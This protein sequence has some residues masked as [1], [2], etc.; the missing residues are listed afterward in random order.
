MAAADSFTCFTLSR[1]W[2]DLK[3]ATCV[4]EHADMAVYA[5]MTAVCLEHER[6][7]I[8]HEQARSARLMVHDCLRC[9]IVTLV[10]SS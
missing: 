1:E 6:A 4:W 8:E 10:T 2:L 3:S 9:N 7:S 5:D